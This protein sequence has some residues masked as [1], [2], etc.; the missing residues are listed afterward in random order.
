MMP[1]TGG[2]SSYFKALLESNLRFPGSFISPLPREWGQKG[3]SSLVSCRVGRQDYLRSGGL[4]IGVAVEEQMW[5]FLN[6]M[7]VFR[8]VMVFIIIFFK[9]SLKFYFKYYKRTRP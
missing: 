6:C 7:D 8:L 4:E 1:E 5:N 2:V 3:L 9:R